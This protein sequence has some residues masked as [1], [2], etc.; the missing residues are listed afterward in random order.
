[1]KKKKED[2][3]EEEDEKRSDEDY[4][5]MDDFILE[6]IEKE[7]DGLAI[8][9]IL[10]KWLTANAC[11]VRNYTSYSETLMGRAFKCWWRTCRPVG[12]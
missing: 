2:E 8:Q 9:E 5:A 3:E 4:T 12:V 7:L 11:P 10:H 6:L 1:M